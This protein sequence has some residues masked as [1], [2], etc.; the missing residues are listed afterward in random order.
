MEKQ[1]ILEPDCFY[2]IFNRGNNKENLFLED[3]NYIHFLNLIKKHLIPIAEIYAYCL[4]KNHFHLAVKIKSKEE[5]ET[6]NY[7][8]DK[9]HQ[10][11]SNLFNAYTKAVNKKYNREG[12]LFKV[13]FKRERIKTEEYL[14]NVI[15]YIHLNPVKHKFIENYLDYKY[16]SINALLSQKP[17]SLMRKEVIE[18]F[19]NRENFIFQ[20][21]EMF[22]KGNYEDF[23]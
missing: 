15:I 22:L 14:R 13:R 1:D 5:L 23:E 19:Y 18:L 11:F 17:T 12:S 3:D 9:L 7:K 2:H 21:N 16:S 4:L 20:H 6:E 8:L 10:P